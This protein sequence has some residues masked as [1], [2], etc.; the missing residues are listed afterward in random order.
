[1][2]LTFGWSGQSGFELTFGSDQPPSLAVRVDCLKDASK[3]HKG[4]LMDVDVSCSGTIVHLFGSEGCARTA[5][6]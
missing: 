2:V 5:K 1:M 4:H 6:T 3:R